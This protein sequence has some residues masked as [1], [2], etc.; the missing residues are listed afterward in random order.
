MVICMLVYLLLNE[1]NRICT[2][3]C[4]SNI[5]VYYSDDDD[6]KV[7]KWYSSMY[8]V[9]R[10]TEMYRLFV[11]WAC[12]PCSLLSNSCR[13]RRNMRWGIWVE[14]FPIHE[15]LDFSFHNTLYRTYMHT[16]FTSW[17]RESIALPSKLAGL[18]VANDHD[19]DDDEDH[20]AFSFS[21]IH[22]QKY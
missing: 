16:L 12:M 20:D 19:G 8:L 21:L 6:E 22:I 13:A 3:S 9:S 7:W 14:L 4:K 18:L 17:V 10:Q 11:S 15:S 1:Q 2:F 5:I